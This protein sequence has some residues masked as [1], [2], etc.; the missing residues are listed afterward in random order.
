MLLSHG[1]HKAFD[2]VDVLKCRSALQVLAVVTPFSRWAAMSQFRA[3]A[4]RVA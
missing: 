2:G 4:L 1:G 3:T